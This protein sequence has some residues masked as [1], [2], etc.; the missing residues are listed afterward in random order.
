M[1]QEQRDEGIFPVFPACSWPTG[2]SQ[3]LPRAPGREQPAA[4]SFPGAFREEPLIKV[5]IS[6]RK[7]NVRE[8]KPSGPREGINEWW[9]GF[10]RCDGLLTFKEYW[11]SWDVGRKPV[12]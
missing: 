6:I 7:F 2:T 5:G 8:T 11:L 4:D 10:L 12:C 9:K 3:L 1:Q